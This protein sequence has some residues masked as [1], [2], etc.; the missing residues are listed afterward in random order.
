MCQRC[1]AGFLLQVLEEDREAGGNSKATILDLQLAPD[2]VIGAVVTPSNAGAVGV[3][4]YNKASWVDIVRGMVDEGFTSLQGPI[5][6][7]ADPSTLHIN[8]QAPIFIPYTWYEAQ[9]L[10]KQVDGIDMCTTLNGR[11]PPGML[12][13]RKANPPPAFWWPK[14]PDGTCFWGFATSLYLWDEFLADV[15][16]TDWVGQ[17][18][19]NPGR[20]SH[21]LT[22]SK[23]HDAPMVISLSEEGFDE[24]GSAIPHRVVSA[25]IVL[26]DQEWT[27]ELWTEDDMEGI[28]RHTTWLRGGGI[29]L[30]VIVTGLVVAVLL[31]NAA[32]M[33]LL[34]AMMPKHIIP[35][36]KRQRV[37]ADTLQHVA[38]IVTDV[39]GYT[40]I[41]DSMEPDMVL[42]ML[43]KMYVAFDD[44]AVAGG[45]H[46]LDIIADSWI[47][48]AGS[49]P[50]VSA[51]QA[52]SRAAD[53]A[54][55]LIDACPPELKIRCG[56]HI[57]PVVAGVLGIR[58]PKWTLIGDT[59]N[60]ASRMEST[61]TASRVQVTQDFRDILANDPQFRFQERDTLVDV[62]GKGHMR[63]FW[64]FDET[65]MHV[66]DDSV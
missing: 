18:L 7:K 51:E 64:L 59:V 6:L 37:V 5:P 47:G 10:T 65:G 31:G 41:A 15:D 49:E 4:L 39:V 3:D 42:R 66:A 62:K 43:Q 61:G 58:K 13:F 40:K 2:T 8:V 25:V 20:F 33:D 55:Q 54:L 38:I 28:L 17:G 16:L 21:R 56:V 26:P 27:L 46:P 35:Y 12:D 22:R 44:C 48:V 34:Q 30:A 1:A 63:S 57:G 29:V 45:V 14:R 52:A 19:A 24:P 60:V 36:L 23:G 9:G 11:E 32:Q 53:V 50:G